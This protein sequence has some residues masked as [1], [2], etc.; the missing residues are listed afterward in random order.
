MADEGGV[1]GGFEEGG[2]GDESVGAGGAAF[3]AGLEVNAAV[4][5]ETEG[6]ILF[7]APGVELGEFGQHITAKR[8]SAETGL[9]GHNEDEIDLG[10]EVAD[11]YGGGA[12]IE[13]D[14]VLAA[15]GANLGEQGAVVEGGLD[16]EADELGAGL[17]EGFYVEVGL[18][19]HEVD[20]EEQGGD[21]AA[22]FG[23]HLGAKGEVGDEVAVHDVE[24]QPGGAGGGDL[25]GA[26]GEADVLTGEDG[27]GENRGKRHGAKVDGDA[28]EGQ[29]R[30]VVE[31]TKKPRR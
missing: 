4:H 2:A 20:V 22:K 17:G 8:L 18:V 23:D 15:E 3:Q 26:F 9:D 24:V 11:G 7:A 12:G 29:G 31:G 25:G 6:E 5:F 21:F 14:A 28:G 19:E 16:V 27:G 30:A 13:D 1:V 10:E